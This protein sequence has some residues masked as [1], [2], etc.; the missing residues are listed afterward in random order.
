MS[1]QWWVARKDL[2]DGRLEYRTLRVEQDMGF[3]EWSAANHD[4]VI[5]DGVDSFLIREGWILIQTVHYT[6]SP[7][8]RP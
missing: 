1:E 7:R 2:P 4:A 8:R 5:D 6:V 3:L